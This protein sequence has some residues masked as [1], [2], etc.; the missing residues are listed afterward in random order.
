MSSIGLPHTYRI[1]LKNECGATLA[2]NAVQV[3]LRKVKF[4]SSGALSFAAENTP[5]DHASTIADNGVASGADQDN[6]TDK[7]LGA[8]VYIE[9]DFPAATNGDPVLIYLQHTTDGG[10]TD[11]DDEEGQLIASIASV[12][13]TTF[14]VVTTI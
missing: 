3:K 14:K 6:S 1:Q 8:D 4:D 9:I 5:Y 2:A 12:A 7:Y 13:S 10:T 11:P